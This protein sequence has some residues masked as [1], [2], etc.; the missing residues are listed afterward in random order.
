[1]VL[2]CVSLIANDAER[3]FMC[4]MAICISSLEKCLD[5]L[6]ASFLNMVISLF[7]IEL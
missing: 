2:I 5:P 3:L 4:L 6:P 1:M 7:M